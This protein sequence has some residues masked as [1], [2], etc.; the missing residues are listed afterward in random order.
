[1]TTSE[2]PEGLETKSVP[3]KYVGTSV[4]NPGDGTITESAPVKPVGDQGGIVGTTEQ[5][6]LEP[7]QA[8]PQP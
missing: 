7:D 1:M 4:Y 2:P 5:A 8:D 6:D 3:G